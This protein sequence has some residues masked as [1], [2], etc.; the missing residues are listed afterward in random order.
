MA[1]KYTEYTEPTPEA[2][3]AITESALQRTAE[4]EAGLAEAI[5]EGA[6][7]ARK[8]AANFLPEVG[9]VLHTGVYN[10]FYWLTYGVVFGALV[11]GRLIPS[12]NAMGEG[13]R[14]GF[15]AAKKAFEEREEA[16]AREEGLA[17]T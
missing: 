4:P 13:V 16:A 10:S 2:A 5:S 11:V 6:S 8:A 17:T 9:K 15:E 3:A 1:R 7:D 14:D 12:D